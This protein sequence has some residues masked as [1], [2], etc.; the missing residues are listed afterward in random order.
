MAVTEELLLMDYLQAPVESTDLDRFS[1]KLECESV[2]VNQVDDRTDN[3][4]RVA[5]YAI[6]QWLQPAFINLYF[7]FFCFVLNQSISTE[8][9]SFVDFQCRFSQFQTYEISTLS[10]LHDVSNR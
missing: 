9:F 6:H 5:G 3:I 2:F 4:S 7:D 8:T 1:I 10:L